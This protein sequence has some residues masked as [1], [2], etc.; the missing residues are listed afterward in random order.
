[1]SSELIIPTGFKL[2]GL[3]NKVQCYGGHEEGGWWYDEY[4]LS[5]IHI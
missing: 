3:Y 2:V 5:L 4:T 1:M